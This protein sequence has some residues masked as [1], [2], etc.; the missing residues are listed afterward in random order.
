MH[1]NMLFSHCCNNPYCLG[2]N[3][4]SAFLL[5]RKAIMNVNTDRILPPTKTATCKGLVNTKLAG[6]MLYNIL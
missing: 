2:S 3:M 6:H 1:L 5:Q 4:S